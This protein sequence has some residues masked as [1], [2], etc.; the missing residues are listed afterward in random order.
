MGLSKLSEQC[1]KCPDKDICD[2]KRMEACAYLPE[3]AAAS[4]VDPLVQPLVMPVMEDQT[5]YNIRIDSETTVQVRRKDFLKQIEDTLYKD[6]RC[7]FLKV[8]S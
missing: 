2:E 8:G 7:D 3:P 1:K 4:L 5:T 6:M